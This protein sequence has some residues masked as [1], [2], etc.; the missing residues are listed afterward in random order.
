MVRALVLA[1]CVA[2]ATAFVSAPAATRASTALSAYVPDGMS[3][4]EYAATKK[5]QEAKKVANKKKYPKGNMGTDVKIWLNQLDKAKQGETEISKTGYHTYAKT[6]YDWRTGLKDNGG[7]P[8]A[9]ATRA[10]GKPAAKGGKEAP[11]PKKNIF[12][13]FGK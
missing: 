13:F 8:R 3:A 10:G 2:A 9:A 12:S 6:K 5:A 11:A 4:S 7:Q 1:L